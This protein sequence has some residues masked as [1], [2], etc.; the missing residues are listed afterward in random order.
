M[1]NAQEQYSFPLL[2]NSE[3]LGCMKELGIPMSE[4]LLKTP[5]PEH[6]TKVCEELLTMFYGWAPEDA[7]QMQFSGVEVFEYPQLHEYSVGHL[8]FHRALGNLA[9]TCGMH[10]FSLRDMVK[11]EYKRVREFLSGIINF[12]KF[13]EEKVA[14]YEEFVERSEQ[15]VNKQQQVEAENRELTSQL[16]MHRTHRQAEE[17]QIEK[18]DAE[19]NRLEEELRQLNYQQADLKKKCTN[20]KNTRQEFQDKIA[21]DQFQLLNLTAEKNKLQAQIVQSPEKTKRE[22][23][24]LEETVERD[25][26]E[27]ADIEKRTNELQQKLDA[28]TKVQKD[29]KKIMT[30]LDEVGVEEAKC[31]AAKNEVRAQEKEVH[32]AETA[33]VE[34]TAQ[35]QALK[36]QYK[37]ATERQGELNARQGLRV[38]AAARDLQ[39]ARELQRDAEKENKEGREKLDRLEAETRAVQHKIAEANRQHADDKATLTQELGRLEKELGNYNRDVL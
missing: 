21:N 32:T 1:A 39:R 16:H 12:A 36:K 25:T 29:M 13:R 33:K 4:E 28:L 24:N 35:E 19:C 2:E 10:N 27:T 20:L 9:A 23:K 22:I 34:L 37:H 26:V 14:L 30:L 17:P 7:T 31:K 5:N 15:L 11:P 3:I 18:L 8:A 38:E 6:F